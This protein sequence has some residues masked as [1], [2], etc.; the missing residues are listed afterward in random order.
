MASHSQPL[1]TRSRRGE[2]AHAPRTLC[3]F[4][5]EK[6]HALQCGTRQRSLATAGVADQPAQVRKLPAAFAHG[7]LQREEG[8]ISHSRWPKVCMHG[9]LGTA[10]CALS[11]KRGNVPRL[12]NSCCF[13]RKRSSCLRLAIA[14]CTKVLMQQPSGKDQHTLGLLIRLVWT[15]KAQRGAQQAFVRVLRAGR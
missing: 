4:A 11:A 9:K 8:R 12:R 15:W 3:K 7:F 2:E 6:S 1:S 13:R 5:C 14:Q 10:L